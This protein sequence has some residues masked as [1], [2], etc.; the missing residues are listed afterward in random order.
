LHI[1]AFGARRS[2][3]GDTQFTGGVAELKNRVT[4]SRDTRTFFDWTV[5]GGTARGRLPIDDYFMLGVENRSA[6]LLRGHTL[7]DHGRYGRSPIGS[8]FV[9][10]NTDLSRRLAT[11][12]FFN[13]LNIPFIAVKWNVF[14]DAA[15]TWDRNR[16]FQPSKLLIDT[17]GG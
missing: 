10:L 17:G 13:N 16:I 5:R 1:E 3:I 15:K 2:V 14:A 9:L 12:P 11:I 8:D 6:N 4:L 7:A